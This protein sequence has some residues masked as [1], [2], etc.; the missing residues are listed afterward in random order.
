VARGQGASGQKASAGWAPILRAPTGFRRIRRADRATGRSPLPGENPFIGGSNG[1]PA[2]SRMRKLLHGFC[3][4]G[5]YPRAWHKTEA[6]FRWRPF[7]SAL[8]GSLFFIPPPLVEVMIWVFSQSS[9]LK[10]SR[11]SSIAQ[12]RGMCPVHGRTASAGKTPDSGAVAHL[13]QSTCP[14]RPWGKP[15]HG[16]NRSDLSML[17]REPMKEP[18]PHDVLPWTGC[19]P[20][21]RAHPLPAAN[22]WPRWEILRNHPLNWE[23]TL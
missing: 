6:T 19:I 1:G 15:N 3:P 8:S 23:K 13:P 20:W 7:Q 2:R 4:G 16:P 18:R 10:G 21:A 9:G 5:P 22:T 14:R 11:K 12:A 17:R